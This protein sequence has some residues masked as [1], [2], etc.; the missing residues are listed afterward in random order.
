[1]DTGLKPLGFSEMEGLLWEGEEI[2]LLTDANTEGCVGKGLTSDEDEGR[3]PRECSAL[4]WKPREE[5]NVLQKVRALMMGEKDGGHVGIDQRSKRTR[6]MEG[7]CHSVHVYLNKWGK[8]GS[9]SRKTHRVQRDAFRQPGV[10]GYLRRLITSTRIPN[11]SFIKCLHYSFHINIRLLLLSRCLMAA[12]TQILHSNPSLPVFPLQTPTAEP[13]SSIW[14]YLQQKQGKHTLF[15]V[16]IS[17]LACLLQGDRI[18]FYAFFRLPL[19]L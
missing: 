13:F 10:G 18:I 19:L 17:V 15:F 16:L 12:L 9:T 4:P 8:W 14:V 5:D 11:S 3:K 6:G 7:A 2:W 1:M